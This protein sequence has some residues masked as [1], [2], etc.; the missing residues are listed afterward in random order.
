MAEPVSRSRQLAEEAIEQLGFKPMLGFIPPT[1][2]EPDRGSICMITATPA[3][4][5]T[6]GLIDILLPELPWLVQ[7]VER[8]QH[9]LINLGFADIPVITPE[10]LIV[11]KCYALRN[12]PDRFQDFD[13]LKE[14]FSAVNELDLDYLRANLVK[15]NLAIPEPVRKFAPKKLV[16]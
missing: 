2:H 15:L 5:E 6:H 4:N 8:A 1:Q 10:D 3:P 7:S 13:D 11:A 12:S 9:N 14:I 16:F